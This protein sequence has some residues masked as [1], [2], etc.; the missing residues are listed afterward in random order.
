[1]FAGET[2]V[3]LLAAARPG[4]GAQVHQA[5]VATWYLATQV[6]VL[7]LRAVFF[8]FVVDLTRHFKLCGAS[9]LV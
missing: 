7:G 9:R 8:A 6:P 1:V 3:L 5:S 2:A 4:L